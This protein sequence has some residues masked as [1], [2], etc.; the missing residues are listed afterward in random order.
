MITLNLLPI[1]EELKYKKLLRGFILFNF[2]LILILVAHFFYYQH[3]EDIIS[4]QE[5]IVNQLRKD[6]AKYKSVLGD[7]AKEKKKSEEAIRR[8]DAINSLDDLRHTLLRVLNTVNESIPNKTWIVNMEKQGNKLHIQ[9]G[10]DS[11][12]NVTKF[13]RS[14]KAKTDL[15]VSL[16]MKDV[17]SE[18]YKETTGVKQQVKYLSYEFNLVLK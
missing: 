15:F 6:V 12:D 9:G 2:I 8:I 16:E 13:A 17:H 3:N 18:N 11:Y 4:K 5:Q 1:K 10:S 14:L 7:L